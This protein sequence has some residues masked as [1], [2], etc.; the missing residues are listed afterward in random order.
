MTPAEATARWLHILGFRSSFNGVET[1]PA[2]PG[3]RDSFDRDE[4]IANIHPQDI[5]IMQQGML[6]VLAMLMIECSQLLM[7]HPFF[8]PPQQRDNDDF[9]KEIQDMDN[10]ERMVREEKEAKQ[11]QQEEEETWMDKCIFEEDEAAWRQWEHH[12]AQRYREWEQWAVLNS[13]PGE[14]TRKRLRVTTQRGEH[15][16]QTDM[17]VAVGAEI[18]IHLGP[19]SSSSTSQSSWEAPNINVDTILS[20]MYG[21]WKKRKIDDDTV[22]SLA[23]IDILGLYNAQLLREVE[24]MDTMQDQDKDSSGSNK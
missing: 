17:E 2:L 3:G 5:G 19:L 24:T 6:R 15:L 23:G 16:Q 9:A 13:V 7:R 1:Q 11:K 12:Q 14:S 21:V 4:H 22:K 8:Q 18:S 10:E 20:N